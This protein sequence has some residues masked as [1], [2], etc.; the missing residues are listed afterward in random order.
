MQKDITEKLIK[1]CEQY[2]YITFDI[3]DTLLKRD[4]KNPSDVF[5]LVEVICRKENFFQKRIDAEKKARE[6]KKSEITL[7]DIYNQLDMSGKEELMETEIEV[8]RRV[9]VANHQLFEVYKYCCNQKK[10]VYFISD[11]YLSKKDIEEFLREN[12]YSRYEK[13]YLSSDIGYTKKNGKLFQYF[14]EKENLKAQDVLHIGDSRY[15][16]FVSPKKNGINAYRI[17]RYF[18]NMRY[19]NF[20]N[21]E[22]WEVDA[23]KCFINN[24]IKLRTTI[25]SR[26]GYEILGPLILVFCEKLKKEV[27]EKNCKIW[28]AARDMFYFYKAYIELYGSDENVEYINLSR[29]SLRPLYAYIKKDVTYSG[30]IFPR[31]CYSLNQILKYLGYDK[32]YVECNNIKNLNE[33]KYLAKNLYNYQELKEILNSPSILKQEAVKARNADK[34]L[35]N[36]GLYDENIILADVGW[37]GTTQYILNEIKKVK[38]LEHYLYGVYAGDVEGTSEKIGA[39]N[40]ET[41][42]FNEND[43]SDF[44]KGVMLFES[45]I[46]APQ[47]TTLEYSSDMKPV[48]DEKYVINKTILEVQRSAMQFIF[49]YKESIL[50]TN[51]NVDANEIK[52]PFEKLVISPKKE[53]VEM[54]G[55][56]I[57]DDNEQLKL[58]SPQ[59]ITFYIKNPTHLI[60]DY[61][62]APWRIGFLYRLLRIRLPYGKLY[63]FVRLVCKKKC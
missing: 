42:F 38:D 39:D 6:I 25:E 49:D 50:F 61:K 56:V 54:L 36:C 51:I 47:G 60:H 53:E 29:K 26:I 27:T 19:T 1:K 28:F 35:S 22:N 62:Y 58:A 59:N 34:Y 10:K 57:Y 12:G 33:K 31:V 55:E 48:L 46:S 40:F 2:E 63:S 37:H 3:F 7:D 52:K 21:D 5:K 18:Y 17:N 13:L 8:E 14:L 11:M 15:S 30:E 4:L 41:I 44:S 16:D 23:F 24:R 43:N 9:L 45:L 32:T 20:A